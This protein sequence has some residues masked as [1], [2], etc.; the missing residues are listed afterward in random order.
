MLF[1]NN[2]KFCGTVF[3]IYLIQNEIFNHCYKMID[4]FKKGKS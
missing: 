1:F 3:D 4:P 2:V